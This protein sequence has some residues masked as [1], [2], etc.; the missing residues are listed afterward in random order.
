MAGQTASLARR[1]VGEA[2][3]YVRDPI[4]YVRGA[5]AMACSIYRMAA[6]SRSTLSPL[7]RERATAR[8][9]AMTEVPLDAL[10]KMAKTAGGTV[11]DAFLAAVAGGCAGTTSGTARP[12]APFGP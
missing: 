8:Y 4:G 3:G 10:K 11:N 6:P 2:I 5:A 7:V 1:G 9:L 12:S